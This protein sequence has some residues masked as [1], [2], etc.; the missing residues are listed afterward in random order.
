MTVFTLCRRCALWLSLMLMGVPASAAPVPERVDGAADLLGLYSDALQRHPSIR[1]GEAAAAAAD[2]GTR[3]ARGKLLPQVTAFGEGLHVDE[4]ITGDFFGLFDV[5]RDQRYERYTYGVNLIQPVIRADLWSGLDQASLRIERA[6]LAEHLVRSALIEDVARRYFNA[7]SARDVLGLALARVEAL[8][9]RRDQVVSQADAGLLTEADRQFAEA[10]LQLART[11][12][13]EVQSALLIARSKLQMLTDRPPARI[14]QLSPSFN[15]LVLQPA[16]E[17]VWVERARTAHPQVL[18]RQIDIR[19]AELEARRTQRLRWPSLDVVGAVVDL[20]SGGGLAGRRDE[21]ELRIGARVAMPIYAGGQVSASIAAAGHLVT[22]AQ[23]ELAT[24]ED[25]AVLEARTAYL[26]LMGG[27]LQLGALRA[28]VDAASKA[29]SATRA[30]FDAGT[31]TTAEMLAT[32]EQRYATEVQLQAM[33]YR[34][35]LDSLRLKRAA[36]ILVV[37]DLIQ[38]NRLLDAPV[39][40]H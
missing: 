38:L 3:I 11:Q 27:Q 17:A 26:Q 35:L 16:D 34:M 39:D 7:L 19:L 2:E 9:Q 14:R 33:R 28:A 6:A 29:E 1:S 23:A 21:R 18:E 12:Q 24:A 15:V 22:R 25:N 5:D 40:L 20:E 32:I 31:R 30:G 13:V 37:A 36:G 8:Q 4:R 10:A